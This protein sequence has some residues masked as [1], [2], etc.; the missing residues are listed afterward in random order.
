MGVN[1][2]QFDRFIMSGGFEASGNVNSLLNEN[3]DEVDIISPCAF[4]GLFKGC[5]SLTIAPELPAKTLAD[6][7]YESMFDGCTSLTQAPV[8]PATSLTIGCY[9]SMFNGCTSLT[10]SP[11]LPSTKLVRDC[12]K[13]MFDN[14][15]S[16]TQAP[17]LHATGLVPWCYS[18]M[19]KGCTSL[20]IAPEL[21]ATALANNCYQNMFDGCSSLD[22][23]KLGYEGNF[24][25]TD[26]KNWVNSIKS[27]GTLY[28][29]GSDT[30]RGVN[31]IPSGWNVVRDKRDRYRYF[32][33]VVSKKSS[34]INLQFSKIDF[35]DLDGNRCPYPIGTTT[36][37]EN[38]TP[39]QNEG[40]DNLIDGTTNTKMCA[41]IDALPCSITFDLG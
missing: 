11:E 30:T 34:D 17:K 7:C 8:L 24:S 28:Y 35:V 15:T 16:L 25:A 19:F 33:M 2:T 39:Y 10:R 20:T 41:K 14:C 31:A 23:I 26:F 40:S 13:G 5:S 27:S 37:V 32:K 4:L 9:K 6:Y 29:N 12:Y 18:Y 22:S 3:F 1:A 36:S 21:P 38:L